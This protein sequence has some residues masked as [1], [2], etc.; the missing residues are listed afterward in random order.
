MEKKICDICE[1][2]IKPGKETYT[3]V[4]ITPVGTDGPN[5]E[6]KAFDICNECLAMPIHQSSLREF[7]SKLGKAIADQFR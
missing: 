2:H 4:R 3:I 5:N 7:L 1:A 6:S